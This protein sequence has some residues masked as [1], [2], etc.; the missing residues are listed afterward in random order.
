MTRSDQES[1]VPEIGPPGLKWR[2]WR[3]TA[4]H[5]ASPRP[6]SRPPRPR[7]HDPAVA[8]GAGGPRHR[9]TRKGGKRDNRQLSPGAG[10]MSILPMNLRVGDRFTE[11]E[12]EWEIITH[13]RA[14]AWW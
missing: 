2:G 13:P 11:G 8:A 5:R 7:P 12:F 9:V 3:R 1:P 10:I 6:Y 14:H 4:G